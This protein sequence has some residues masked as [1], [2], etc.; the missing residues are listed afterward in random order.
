MHLT[1]NHF[2]HA[3]TMG[4]LSLNVLWRSPLLEGLSVFAKLYQIRALDFASYIML[5]FYSP[6]L[7]NVCM[8]YNFFN[9]LRKGFYKNWPAGPVLACLGW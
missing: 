8:C 2:L 7:S 3:D 9:N 1:E 6:V 4:I 5:Y